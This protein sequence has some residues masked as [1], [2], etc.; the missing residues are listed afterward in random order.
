M[1]GRKRAAGPDVKRGAAPVTARRP[2][3]AREPTTNRQ[4]AYLMLQPYDR[5]FAI[6]ASLPAITASRTSDT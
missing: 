4:S 5:V 1:A 2:A 3:L 6:G